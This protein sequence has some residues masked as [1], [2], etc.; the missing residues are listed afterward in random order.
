MIPILTE[1]LHKDGSFSKP[2]KDVAGSLLGG[3]SG[4]EAKGDQ[5][6]IR[7]SRELRKR[8]RHLQLGFLETDRIVGD[9]GNKRKRGGYS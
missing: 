7:G 1:F 2:S 8:R 3:D 4:G 9:R 5:V 6:V